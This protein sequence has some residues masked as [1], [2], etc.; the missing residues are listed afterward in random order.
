MRV[1]K[2][3]HACV[4][5]EHGDRALLVDPGV[6]TEPDAYEGVVDL[7]VTHEHADHI[8]VDAL[9]A[10]ASADSAF[11]VRAPAPVAEMLVAVGVPA[12]VVS[13]GDV[14]DVA[15]FEVAVVGGLHAEVYEGL[16]GC[17]N[18][19][20]V[21]ESRVYHPG[22]SFVVP[23][24]RDLDLLLAPTS[25]PWLKLAEAIDVG[26]AVAPRR[27]ISIHDALLNERAESL[28]DRWMDLKGGTDY[29]R[30]AAGISLDL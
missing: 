13:T 25:G 1:T 6:W 9:A 28:V 21:V 30:L 8:D 23:E 2:F 11:T 27:A 16:P 26:R 29:R 18:V 10:R 7:L 5:I 14:V 17:A 15:G 12:L 24:H 22:D 20:Y 3:T 4:R 19:G